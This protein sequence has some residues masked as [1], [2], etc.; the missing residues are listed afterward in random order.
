M[1]YYYLNSLFDISD[2][3]TLKSNVNIKHFEKVQKVQ[4]INA[5]ASI[6][7]VCLFCEK[8]CMSWMCVYFVVVILKIKLKN[9]IFIFVCFAIVS[10]NLITFF[11][12]CCCE[13]EN[14]AIFFLLL[15]LCQEVSSR[16]VSFMSKLMKEMSKSSLL[17][18][19]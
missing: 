8:L 1:C 18:I 9:F 5:C 11:V 17:G 6:C 12:V 19:E 7:S 4:T 16:N 14:F 3:R 2:R 15:H 10:R 13:C